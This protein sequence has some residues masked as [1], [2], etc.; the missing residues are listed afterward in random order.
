MVKYKGLE[1]SFHYGATSNFDSVIV[2][3]VDGPR[4]DTKMYYTDTLHASMPYDEPKPISK[5]LFEVEAL[6]LYI[7]DRG[8]HT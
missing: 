7:V 8:H 3:M 5:Q 2:S 6:A 4:H 1:A